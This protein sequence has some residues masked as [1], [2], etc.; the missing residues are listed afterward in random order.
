MKYFLWVTGL[1]ELVCS[2]GRKIAWKSFAKADTKMT[3][4]SFFS[5]YIDQ[6]LILYFR[7]QS[8]SF[9]LIPETWKELHDEENLYRAITCCKQRL[10]NEMTHTAMLSNF[11]AL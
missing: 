4:S 3:D 8:Y 7:I 10:V 2:G 11:L 6:E 9:E 5:K 1:L